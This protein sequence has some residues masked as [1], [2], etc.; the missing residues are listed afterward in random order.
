MRGG[1]LSADTPDTCPPAT[2]PR[3]GHLRTLQAEGARTPIKGGRTH[4]GGH[5]SGQRSERTLDSGE[6]SRKNRGGQLS[7][8]TFNGLGGHLGGSLEPPVQPSRSREKTDDE[9][10]ERE[11]ETPRLRSWRSRSSSLGLPRDYIDP[12]SFGIPTRL[13][14]AHFN[15]LL[16]DR[17][18]L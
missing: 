15:E 12:E 7:A 3:G 9:R 5:L 14:G 17:R 8:D 16:A 18:I 10:S 2:T 1:H 11:C 4:A 6:F 13:G